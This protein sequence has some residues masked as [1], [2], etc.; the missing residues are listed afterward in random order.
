MANWQ[1]I[2]IIVAIYC[3]VVLAVGVF[4]RTKGQVSLS[5]YFVC[6]HSSLYISYGIET[7]TI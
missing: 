5:D 4:T 6:S 2:L 3:A 1:I 7:F